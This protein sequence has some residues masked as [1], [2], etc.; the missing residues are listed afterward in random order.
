[1]RAPRAPVGLLVGGGVLLLLLGAGLL[2]PAAR[3]R[4]DDRGARM[5]P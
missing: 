3:S 4:A 1:M 5:S 2:L